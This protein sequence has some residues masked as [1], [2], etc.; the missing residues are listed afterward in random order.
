MS[1]NKTS[2]LS[3]AM[4]ISLA[5][6]GGNSDSPSAVA[7][8][9][10]SGKAVDGYL[11]GSTVLCDV[12]K[13]GT[14]DTGEATTTT[15]ASGNFT[16]AAGCSGT[17]VVSG[18]T[19]AT[20]TYP[21]T[22]VLEAPAGSAVVTP[23]TT[24][25]TDTGLS[26]AQL[27]TALSLPA[28]TDVTTI[29]PADGSNQELLRR[30]LAVQQL[31]QQMANTLGILTGS[32]SVTALYSK[33]AQS[34]ATAIQAS[35]TTPLV[36]TDG[37]VNQAVWTSAVQGAVSATRADTSFSSFTISDTNLLA[38]ATQIASQA[39]SFLGA[40]DAD[41][42][43]LILSLQNPALPPV[44]LNASANYV[45]LEDDSVLIN[46]TEVPVDSLAGGV[47]VDSPSTV[48]V[49]LDVQGTPAI[50]TVASFG[51]EL[52]EVGGQ[53]RVFQILIDKINIKTV[54]GGLSI[55]PDAT[56][57]VFVYGHTGSGTDFNVTVANP[58]AIPLI[59]ADNALTLD[60]ASLLSTVLG[61]VGSITNPTGEVPTA[62]SGTFGILVAVNGLPVRSAD[63]QTALPQT[64]V[65]VTG[66]GQSVIG[67]G[68]SGT[69][70][71][72]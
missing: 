47:T 2:V 25:L 69:L 52:K 23:L 31:V 60:I 67:V 41:L 28:G 26:V 61:G 45:S 27:A 56:S 16:F 46:G 8:T 9:P 18:G 32:T 55:T 13:N 15:D 30:T 66:T 65:A 71:I 50:D 5:A 39:Q 4:A 34:L 20:T 29:D 48:G 37:T 68:V 10:M 51:L 70:I 11:A 62:I 12:N 42:A 49:G 43:N 24:L 3:F 44:E 54:E 40:A 21:F 64:V 14:A 1:T 63:G 33:V 22:G 7:P 53:N 38:V 35:P 17:I 36:S 19:D 59:L 57:K 72:P 6:C 58:A